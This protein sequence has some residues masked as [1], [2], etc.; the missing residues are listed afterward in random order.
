MNMTPCF[1]AGDGESAVSI[2]DRIAKTTNSKAAKRINAE[3]YRSARPLLATLPCRPRRFVDVAGGCYG[4]EMRILSTHSLYPLYLAGMPSSIGEIFTSRLLYADHGKTGAARLNMVLESTNRFGLQCPEC[5]KKSNLEFGYRTSLVVHCISF[6][7]RCP[8]H[9]CL[10]SDDNGCSSM[11]VSLIKTGNRLSEHN[12]MLYSKTALQLLQ[13]SS[14]Q[15]VWK[16]VLTKLK[17]KNYISESGW[18]K[19][20]DLEKACLKLFSEGFEDDRLNWLIKEGRL[21][22]RCVRTATRGRSGIAPT[23][24]I[25]MDCLVDQIDERPMSPTVRKATKKA[26]DVS[27]DELQLRRRSWEL[28]HQTSDGLTRTQESKRDP[29]T[30]TWLYRHDKNWLAEHRVPCAK[31]SGGWVASEI[32]PT[33]VE[34]IQRNDWRRQPAG[35][36]LIPRQSA[37][38]LRLALGINQWAFRRVASAIGSIGPFAQHPRARATFI[39]DRYSEALTRLPLREKPWALSS[40]ARS[41]SLRPETLTKLLRIYHGG[42]E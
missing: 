26:R 40:I 33:V 12:A 23:C 13:D 30:F 22:S 11:E 8:Y 27:E 29:A 14:R 7:S 35:S 24:L 5:R 34:T 6:M 9:G 15:P 42:S 41:A 25:I 3:C 2:L 38:Q 10:L 21:V 39:L 28:V 20:A 37:Y 32:P 16:N 17:A 31:S 4:N 19:S 1:R 36:G 18:F